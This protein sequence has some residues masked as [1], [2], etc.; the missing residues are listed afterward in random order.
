MSATLLC[1]LWIA[2]PPTD[3]GML[4]EGLLL[5]APPVLTA[6]PAAADEQPLLP[7]R[8]GRELLEASRDALRRWARP[9]D[10]EAEAAAR[11]LLVLYREV[12]ADLQ[13]AASQRD[14][15][16][17]VLRGRLQ[18][19]AEQIARVR[20]E[21]AKAADDRPENVDAAGRHG[22]LA[23]FGGAGGFGRGFG[24]GPG[25]AGL[26]A[27][28][29]VGPFG[30]EPPDAGEDLVEVIQKTIAPASWD[31]HGGLG[32]IYYWRPG[33]AL[34]IRQRGEVHDQIGDLLWQMQ[35][36]GQ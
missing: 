23:Q 31:I 19:L 7:P 4:G 22:V 21:Q 34:I 17:V 13:L 15:L 14:E 3:G 24:M 33:R 25:G 2:A 1:V 18:A 29:P 16:R 28:G 20:A 6:P 35:R 27:G 5:S 11:E 30:M 12:E 9:A 26:G 36:L 32:A 10:H 8:T